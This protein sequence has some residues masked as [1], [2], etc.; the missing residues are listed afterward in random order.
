MQHYTNIKELES[1][2]NTVKEAI[3]LKKNE[4]KFKFLVFFEFI[5]KPSNAALSAEGLFILLKT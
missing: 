1:L 3:G 2:Q 5:A 4:L